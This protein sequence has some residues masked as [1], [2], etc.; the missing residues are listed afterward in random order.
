MQKIFSS[1]D[2]K[3]VFQISAL[4]NTPTEEAVGRLISINQIIIRG[5]F[6]V[7]TGDYTENRMLH[8]A[9]TSRH[10]ML[11]AGGSDDKALRTFD[12]C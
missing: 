10:N 3:L 1:G 12:S 4:I 7:P 9:S 5:F 2:L 11:I 6:A 8:F